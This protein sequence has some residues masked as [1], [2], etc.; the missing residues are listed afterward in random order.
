MMFPEQEAALR[1]PAFLDRIARAHLRGM[2]SFVRERASLRRS[3]D[4]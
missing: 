1:N 3:A 4:P 2:E